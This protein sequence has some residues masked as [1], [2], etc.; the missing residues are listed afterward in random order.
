MPRSI[1]RSRS[2][3]FDRQCG[4]CF[5]CDYPMWLSDIEHYSSLYQ[6]SLAQAGQHRCTAEHLQARRDGGGNSRSNIVA[7]CAICNRRR[8]TRRKSMIPEVYRH[9]VH[10]RLRQGRW[11]V[12]P[13]PPNS[14]LLTDTYTS[15]LRAQRGAAKRER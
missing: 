5:Y 13:M 1:A 15:P 9:F 2:A 3:S 8:H 4:R 12:H 11:H 14:A 10:S 6:L 7:A